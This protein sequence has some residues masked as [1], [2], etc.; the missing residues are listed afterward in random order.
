MSFALNG[1][2]M[3]VCDYHDLKITTEKDLQSEVFQHENEW[4]TENSPVP[5]WVW[6]NNPNAEYA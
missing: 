6:F 2:A 3:N 5:Q 1:V 4:T